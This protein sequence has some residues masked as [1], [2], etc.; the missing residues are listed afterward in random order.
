MT[1]WSFFSLVGPSGPNK[2]WGNDTLVVLDSLRLLIMILGV[3]ILLSTPMIIHRATVL[4]QKVRILGCS[5]FS[6]VAILT[7]YNHFGDYA[8]WRLAVNLIATV[9]TAWGYWSFQRWETG[10]TYSNNEVNRAT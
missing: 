5:L 7:E 8:H 2:P 1:I 10:P 9:C 3:M 6:L 4:G